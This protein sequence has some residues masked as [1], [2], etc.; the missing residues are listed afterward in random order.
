MF[1]YILLYYS[2]I[3]IINSITHIFKCTENIEKRLT[4][5]AIKYFVIFH[6]YLYSFEVVLYP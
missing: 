3:N 1:K 6:N 2:I 4:Q 5:N